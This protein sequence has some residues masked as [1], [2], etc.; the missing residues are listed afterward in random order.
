MLDASSPTI[1]IDIGIAQGSCIGPLMFIVYMNDIFRCSIELNFLIHAD[2]TA[3][4]VS[5]VHIGQFISIMNQGLSHVY[6][7]L[8]M[9]NLSLNVY[10]TNNVIFNRRNQINLNVLLS[11]T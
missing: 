6:R 10:K 9:N 5:G 4:Y 2:D 11:I 1:L 8:Y 7:W 3:L